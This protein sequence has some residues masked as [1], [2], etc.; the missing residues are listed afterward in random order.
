MMLVRVQGVKRAVERVSDLLENTQVIINR[1]LTKTLTIFLNS[2]IFFLNVYLFLSETDRV[3]VG[4]GQRE[5][6]RE[7]PKQDPCCQH[8]A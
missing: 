5:R 1:M 7:N 8:R 3:Q 6:E 4:E 2:L